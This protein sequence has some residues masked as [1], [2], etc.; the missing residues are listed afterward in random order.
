MKLGALSVTN[1]GSYPSFEMDFSNLGLALIYG[2]TGAG[3]STTMDM[4]C[5]V[6]Y[7]VTAKDGAADDV[8]SWQRPGEIT[9]GTQEVETPSGK[10]TVT[11]IRGKNDLYWIEG[12]SDEKTRGKDITETQ[13]L[14]EKRLGVDADTYITGA[15]FHE[16]SAT[17]SFFVSKA[18]DRRALFEKIAHLDLPKRIADGAAE[19]RKQAK[20]TLEARETHLARIEGQL[21]ELYASEANLTKKLYAWEDKHAADKKALNSEESTFE[22]NRVKRLEPLLAARDKWDMEKHVKL[23]ALIDDIEQ[24]KTRPDSELVPRTT[25]PHETCPRCKQGIEDPNKHAL[26]EERELARRDNLKAIATKELKLEQL[27]NLNNSINPYPARI[28][29]LSQPNPYTDQLAALVKVTNPYT[30]LLEECLQLTEDKKLQEAL[31]QTA[32]DAS[33]GRIAALNKIYDLSSTL[34]AELLKS[35]VKSI[36]AETNNILTKHFDAEVLVSFALDGDSLE[37]NLSKS[38]YPCN[39]KQLSKGQRGL[40]K[41]SFSRAVMKA[42]SNRSGVHFD[43]LFFD[44]SLDGLDESL[45][46]RAF[47]LFQEMEGEHS[48]ILLID[49]AQSFQNLF[50]KKY[51]IIMTGDVSTMEEVA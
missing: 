25:T 27:K 22:D 31:S 50:S 19:Q 3:K 29:A 14:L 49:H 24:I 5:W 23:G 33:I 28:E 12:D 38:G 9:S 39:Y 47:D 46:V 51:H 43:V 6:L 2:N 32:V 15:Y 45:K 42:A 13:K 44:E 34:R 1:F 41:L 20:T 8:K 7:G 35:A 17:G 30:I 11:R 10:I 37:V 40:L 36:E 16:F 4:S 48:S 26:A 18:K 21:A